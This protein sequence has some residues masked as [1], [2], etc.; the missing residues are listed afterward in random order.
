MCGGALYRSQIGKSSLVT[1]DG[2]GVFES[3]SK[4]YH[5][6]TQIITGVLEERLV[7]LC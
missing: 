4:I 2:K 5:P 1:M 3:E 6:K 7:K